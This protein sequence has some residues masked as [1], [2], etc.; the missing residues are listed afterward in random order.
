VLEY[1]RIEVYEDSQT[2]VPHFNRY[3]ISPQEYREKTQPQPATT[4]T[5]EPNTT[6]NTEAA[7]GTATD[8]TPVT[9]AA[10]QAGN[11]SDNASSSETISNDGSSSAAVKPTVFYHRVMHMAVAC[12]HKP[13]GTIYFFEFWDDVKDV[14]QMS[15]NFNQILRSTRF[16]T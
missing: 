4:T 15:A 9:D 2:K 10:S 7:A 11:S 13:L 16:L 3:W 8:A 6:A 5:A 12:Y 1:C 14:T